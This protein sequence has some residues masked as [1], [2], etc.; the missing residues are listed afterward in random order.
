MF[1]LVHASGEP[2]GR[3]HAEAS[4]ADCHQAQHEAVAWL[5]ARLFALAVALVVAS[6]HV[7]IPIQT[8]DC[9]HPPNSLLLAMESPCAGVS[10]LVVG[11]LQEEVGINSL[12]RE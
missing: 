8:R 10:A 4:L 12:H 5:V 3:S 7:H 6:V 2:I 11:L 1:E 9:P